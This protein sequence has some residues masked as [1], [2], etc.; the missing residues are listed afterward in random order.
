MLLRGNNNN[1]YY[2]KNAALLNGDTRSL[3][4]TLYNKQDQL[5]KINHLY[6][7]LPNAVLLPASTAD[8]HHF[9]DITV[10]LSNVRLA[11]L[12]KEM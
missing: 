5:K 9:Q 2:Y 12:P 3:K 4:Y 6:F 8:S 7:V 10:S 1:Y 11:T